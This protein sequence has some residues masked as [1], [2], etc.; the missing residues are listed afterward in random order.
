MAVRAGADG[1][2]CVQAP[3]GPLAGI[4]RYDTDPLVSR[5]VIGDLAS[6]VFDSG[7]TPGGGQPRQGLRLGRR[8]A[9]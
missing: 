8:R 2:A 6:C 4:R 5:E 3:A 1:F 9:G 7:L